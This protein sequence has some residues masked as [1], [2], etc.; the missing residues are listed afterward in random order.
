MISCPNYRLSREP[1]AVPPC[2]SLRPIAPE[3]SVQTPERPPPPSIL[4][5]EPTPMLGLPPVGRRRVRWQRRPAIQRKHSEE[6]NKLRQSV[7]T[8]QTSNELFFNLR[9]LAGRTGKLSAR[10]YHALRQQPLQCGIIYKEENHKLFGTQ[11]SDSYS[12][13]LPSGPQPVS[14]QPT[15]WLANWLLRSP[16]KC[17]SRSNFRRARS[18]GQVMPAPSRSSSLMYPC[19]NSSRSS[20]IQPKGKGLY[21]T[22][23]LRK[24]QEGATY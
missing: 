21:G 23:G 8:H 9:N 3:L 7:G 4:S 24:P 13:T 10:N 6:R 1:P 18:R 2:S 11:R 15:L 16:E 12:P 17:C 22:R 19:D 14:H 5:R 20:G